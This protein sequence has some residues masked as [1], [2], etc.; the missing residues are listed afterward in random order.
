MESPPS[1]DDES[2][3]GDDKNFD[4]DRYNVFHKLKMGYVSPM[5]AKEE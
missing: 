3:D 4:Q 1:E 2:D 5:K